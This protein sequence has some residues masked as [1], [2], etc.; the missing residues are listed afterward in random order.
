ME[1]V[2]L[3]G[4]GNKRGIGVWIWF[5]IMFVGMWLWIMKGGVIER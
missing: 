1:V 2:C 4:I 3:I 5:V